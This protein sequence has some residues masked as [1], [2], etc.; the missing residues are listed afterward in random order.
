MWSDERI[1]LMKRM[2]TDGKSASEIASDL[3][4]VSRSAVL[5]KARRLGL[6]NR[7]PPA[8]T[9]AAARQAKGDRAK[10][11][12]ARSRY[13]RIL[14]KR[15]AMEQPAAV[16]APIL[17]GDED[18]AKGWP[19]ERGANAVHFMAHKIGQCRMPLWALDA[20]FAEKFVCG[21]PVAEGEESW[22]APH[23]QTTS[24]PPSTK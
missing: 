8:G 1:E 5:G 9:A 11:P 21:D 22:C 16:D 18:V 7:R 3:G 24:N 2:W 13:E 19:K 14:N 12:P 20:P 17:E 15:R 4:L 10:L 23:R 6:A